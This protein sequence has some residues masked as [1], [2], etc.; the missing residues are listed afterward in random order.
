MYKRQDL[1][2]FTDLRHLTIDKSS[3][4]D[5][6]D[7]KHPDLDTLVVRSRKITI[8]ESLPPNLERALFSRGIPGPLN[9]LATTKLRELILT[10][11]SS[12]VDMAE[13]A[14]CKNLTTLH[15]A[16][17]GWRADRTQNLRA[18]HDV[19]LEEIGVSSGFGLKDLIGHPT[20]RQV[21]C[22]SNNLMLPSELQPLARSAMSP[23]EKAFDL[24]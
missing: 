4:V 10:D 17:H 6:T 5:L 13:L 23:R 21:S 3:E 1:S 24:S 11:M 2:E 18:L 20:L 14:G 12:A 9:A 19:P 8:G 22:Y 15:L 16:F 7:L